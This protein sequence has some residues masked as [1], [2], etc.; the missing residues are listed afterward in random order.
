MKRVLSLIMSV[1]LLLYMVPFTV[2]A[3]SD[4]IEIYTAEQLRAV[5]DN[6]SGNYKLMN[7]IDLS[8]YTAM[9]GKYDYNSNGW[10]PIGSGGMYGSNAFAGV[11]DGNGYTISGL[12][13]HVTSIPK[14]ASSK[15]AHIGLF[16]SNSGVI[17]NLTVEGMVSSIYESGVPYIG[18]I[19]AYNSGTIQSCANKCSVNM[20]YNN[21]STYF[22]GGVA[23]Y[24]K[25]T[26][27]ECF[28]DNYVSISGKKSTNSYSVYS[29]GI[30][31][32]TGSI[33]NCYNAGR[34]SATHS[35]GAVKAFSGG[36]NVCDKTRADISLCY[37]VGDS[38]YAIS[39]VD[40]KKSYY[41]INSG[42]DANN[43]V[44][45]LTQEQMKNAESF[46]DFDFE[47]V[48]EIDA[49][50]GYSYPQLKS[51]RQVKPIVATGIEIESMPE[52]LLYTEGEEL[53]ITGLVVNVV[54]SNGE[55][56]P[57]T[58]YTLSGFE[59]VEGTYEV[60]VAYG[61]FTT[62]FIVTVEKPLPLYILGD[63]D[64]NGK[65]NVSDATQIQRYIA[66]LTVVEEF[67]FRAADV[68]IDT[69]LSVIDVTNIQRYIAEYDKN[70]GIGNPVYA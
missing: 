9:G 23:G 3:D 62:S 53:E 42:Y 34:I 7:D 14:G 25:G 20:N 63:C 67:N 37:N 31:C 49:E 55:K 30:A 18:G 5:D 54:Y 4:V 28:N 35:F 44:T 24:N 48:W 61:D 65:V 46:A 52:K 33:Y 11:F 43:C 60:V 12:R 17:C 59:S 47:N 58:D 36:I 19:V 41:L 50:C 66:Q 51:N 13:I 6:L 27:K 64:S 69:K 68:N 15:T 57:T 56:E 10:E 22:A 38:E 40:S 8:T 21:L 2:S 70:S 26:I 29:A 39:N 16:A 45:M 32:G 1:L